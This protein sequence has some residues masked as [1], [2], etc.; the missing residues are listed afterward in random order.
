MNS[1]HSLFVAIYDGW[2]VKSAR[3]RLALLHIKT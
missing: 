3:A 2:T 1:S